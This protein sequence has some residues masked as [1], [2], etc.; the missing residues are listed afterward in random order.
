MTFEELFKMESAPLYL[1]ATNGN[2]QTFKDLYNKRQN[3]HKDA[4][5]DLK[6]DSLIQLRN[7]IKNLTTVKRDSKNDNL[8]EGLLLIQQGIFDYLKKYYYPALEFRQFLCDRRVEIVTFRQ[9][10]MKAC[11]S[12]G[13]T[14]KH[15]GFYFQKDHSTVIHS[16]YVIDTQIS[17]GNRAYIRTYEI[18]NDLFIKH[19]GES[20]ER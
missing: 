9:C 4:T 1:Q 11:H 13:L 16:V 7:K 17:I 14:L 12:L 18:V 15:I 6:V 19:L 10:F 2:L 3:I 5:N 20:V 8:M